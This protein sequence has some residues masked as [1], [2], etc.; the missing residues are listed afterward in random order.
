MESYIRLRCNQPP[1]I[2]E[3]DPEHLLEGI[4]EALDCDAIE[5]V[6]FGGG[7]MILDD[8]GKLIDKPCN[9]VA[10][11]AYHPK[12]DWIAGDVLLAGIGLRDGEQDIVPLDKNLQEAT[13]ADANR[14]WNHIMLEQEQMK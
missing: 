10:S 2:V 5:T 6:P 3:I 8:S 1:D 14:I 13:L 4:R 11:L 12:R 9:P 7:L